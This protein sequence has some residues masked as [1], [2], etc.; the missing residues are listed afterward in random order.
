MANTDGQIIGANSHGEDD[1]DG[2]QASD[3]LFSSVHQDGAVAAIN[4]INELN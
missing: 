1:G 3:K 2:H 4:K